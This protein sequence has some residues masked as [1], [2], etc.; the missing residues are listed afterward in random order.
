MAGRYSAAHELAVYELAP[1]AI[2]RKDLE[3]L[4]ELF[5]RISGHPV[6]GWEV[7]GKVGSVSS[8]ATSAPLKLWDR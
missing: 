1:E 8:A 5:Q 7:R 6:D 3:L 4:E 2:M